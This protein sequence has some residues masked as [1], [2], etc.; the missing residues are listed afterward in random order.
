MCVSNLIFLSLSYFYQLSFFINVY[1]AL[2]IHANVEVGLPVGS[3]QRYKFFNKISYMIGGYL[4]SLNDIEHG[5]EYFFLVFLFLVF[6]FKV[7]N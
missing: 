5:N 4:Y 3:W 2:V 1:N 6:R 7:C